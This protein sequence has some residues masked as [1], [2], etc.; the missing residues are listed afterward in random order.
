MIVNAKPDTETL[1]PLRRAAMLL[2]VLGEQTASEMLQQLSEDDV[3][4][5]SREDIGNVAAAIG[6]RCPEGQ[7]RSSPSHFHLQRP[8][9]K[10]PQRFSPYGS[11]GR[12]RRAR[13]HRL[14]AQTLDADI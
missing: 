7:P 8:G 5:V 13:R 1:S 3:Q 14:R 12:L 2:I 6:G 9:R 4:R 11:G 10:R